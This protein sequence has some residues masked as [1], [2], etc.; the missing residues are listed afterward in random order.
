M[1]TARHIV[2]LRGANS[3]YVT[4]R[5]TKLRGVPLAVILHVSD[6]Q[7]FHRAILPLSC[8]LLVRHRLPATLVS[9]IIRHRRSLSFK[10]SATPKMYRSASLEPT[11]I[12]DLYSELVCTPY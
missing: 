6:P 2:L 11:Q 8:H 5:E 1:L 3:C 12:D 4:Y 7:L 10:V 9:L